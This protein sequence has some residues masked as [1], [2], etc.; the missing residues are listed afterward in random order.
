MSQEAKKD[1]VA[2]FSN[3]Q[4]EGLEQLSDRLKKIEEW[5]LGQSDID[6]S[7]IKKIFEKLGTDSFPYSIIFI[8]REIEGQKEILCLPLPVKETKGLY[9]YGII[10]EKELVYC[11][12]PHPTLKENIWA[13]LSDDHEMSS[14]LSHCLILMKN[15]NSRSDTILC[16]ISGKFADQI[17]LSDV[18]TSL[19]EEQI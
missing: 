2:A 17:A 10:G 16:W 15:S 7:E 14:F 19:E 5:L 13:N 9:P 4:G 8:L 1:M 11:L 18:I 6:S 3:E 12:S